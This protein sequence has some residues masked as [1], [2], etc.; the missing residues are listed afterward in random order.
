MMKKVVE[1]L[2]S[3]LATFLRFVRAAFLFRATKGM[4]T[5]ALRLASIKPKTLEAK[6]RY[7]M[8]K[9]RNPNLVIFA[10]KVRVRDLVRMKV[11]EEYLAKSYGVFQSLASVSRDA[12]PNNFV[13]KANHGSGA[14]VICWDGVP[15][16]R[17]L[18]NKE[19][20]T[21]KSQLIHPG[22]LVWEDLLVLTNKW[23]RQ[24]YGWRIGRY[25]E[26]AYENIDPLLLIEELI[27][28]NGNLPV[29]YKFTMISGKCA[30]IQV[31]VARFEKHSRALYS[32]DWEP[33]EAKMLF[34]KTT[35]QL[36]RPPKLDEMLQIAQILAAGTDFLRVDLYHADDRIVFGELTNYPNGGLPEVWPK[37]LSVK[38]AASWEPSY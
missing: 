8:L 24:D 37:A 3:G 32:S 27:L 23:M 14:I 26:W 33:I 25:P 5:L 29:D 18:D 11:G 31:D 38:L 19:R 21:W 7:K 4:S 28:D 2:P 30:Y 34:P 1:L 10:D 16:G 17:T 13:V 20:V 35:Q 6:I 9:D 12:L 36:M 15:R 22:D